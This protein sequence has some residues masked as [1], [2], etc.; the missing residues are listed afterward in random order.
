MNEPI[1]Q[2]IVCRQKKVKRRLL[3]IV[4]TPRGNVEFDPN[5][6]EEGR[7]LYVC[8]N[9]SCIQKAQSKDLVS[10]FFGKQ[11]PVS[12]YFRMAEHLLLYEKRLIKKL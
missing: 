6:K 5:Q 12:L 9:L 2:C 10:R 4:R 1:R 8:S 3:R 11:I 7:G